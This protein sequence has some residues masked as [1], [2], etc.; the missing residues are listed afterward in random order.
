MMASINVG[1]SLGAA[2]RV[3]NAAAA[4]LGMGGR[5]ASVEVDPGTLEIG[6]RGGELGALP[7]VLGL[8]VLVIIF[9]A[10][11]GAVF[12]DVEASSPW[13]AEAPPSKLIA[14]V[15]MAHAEHVIEYHVVT[16]GSCWAQVVGH[17]LPPVALEAGDVIA[18]PQGDA[19]ILSSKPGMRATSRA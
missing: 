2:K 4:A 13:V 9:T 3:T 8:V 14:P 5:F 19:H 6:L 15:L 16:K 11:K 10:L 12:F 7:A 1:S 18:F 17:D